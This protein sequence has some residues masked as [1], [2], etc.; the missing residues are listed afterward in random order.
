MLIPFVIWLKVFFPIWSNSIE[1]I[2]T[3][4]LAWLQFPVNF[5]E[6]KPWLNAALMSHNCS[7]LVQPTFL[8]SANFTPTA[9]S[10]SIFIYTKARLILPRCSDT[11]ATVLR[12]HHH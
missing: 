11:V 2:G 9:K 3:K 6:S 10:L 12:L 4:L 7:P 8:E 1:K 5:L